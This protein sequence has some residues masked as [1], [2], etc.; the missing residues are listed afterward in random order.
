MLRQLVTDNLA[1]VLVV[2]DEQDADGIGFEGQTEHPPTHRLET[3]ATVRCAEWHLQLPYLHIFRLGR[4]YPCEKATQ[5]GSPERYRRALPRPGHAD[6]PVDGG[7]DRAVAGTSVEG[8]TL[9]KSAANEV[10]ELVT[11]G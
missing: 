8:L 9:Q 2:F 3:A 6:H 11:E 5:S 4:S 7:R 10:I 1:V